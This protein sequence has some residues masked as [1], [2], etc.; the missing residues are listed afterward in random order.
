MFIGSPEA[1]TRSPCDILTYVAVYNCT[2]C[3]KDF[4][5]KPC[6][7]RRS[8][9]KYCSNTCHYAAVR[10]GKHIPCD[11]CGKQLYR[12]PKRL[13]LSK[14]KK[15][16]CNKSCQTIWRNKIFFGPNHKSWKDG[17]SS[18]ASI[19]ALSR[20]GREKICELCK[21]ADRRV[22]AVHHK[23]RNRLNNSGVNL[24][25]LCHNCHFL[26]HHYNV[27]HDRGLLKPRC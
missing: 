4:K 13:R 5:R 17:H 9:G 3:G 27:G 19:T 12:S 20:T 22:L 21:T 14:Y 1:Y 15:Y 23:D 24:A 2:V 26:V 18:S 10:T 7:V 8:G 11:T 6:L 25:W 16:F